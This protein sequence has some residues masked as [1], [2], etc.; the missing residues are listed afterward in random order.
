MGSPRQTC[1]LAGCTPVAPLPTSAPGPRF[2]L[3]HLHRDWG[4]RCRIIGASQPPLMGTHG[5]LTGYSGEIRPPAHRRVSASVRL[6]SP[7]GLLHSS[8]CHWLA[9]SAHASHRIPRTPAPSSPAADRALP[10]SLSPSRERGS[11]GRYRTDAVFSHS[12][13]ARPGTTVA[14]GTL[15]PA[16]PVQARPGAPCVCVCAC[17]SMCV[18][19]CV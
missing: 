16:H 13:N 11:I 3:P 6:A 18:C 9:G 8:P 15:V 2:F 5:V 14:C 10:Q 1:A 4:L 19:V 7:M 17:P 12:A